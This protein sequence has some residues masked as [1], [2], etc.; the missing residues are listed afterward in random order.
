MRLQVDKLV[1][2]LNFLQARAEAKHK[3]TGSGIPVQVEPVL[4]IRIDFNPDPNTDPA[5]WL[6]PDTD[7][8][9]QSHL[10]RIQYGS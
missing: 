6:N 1:R 2:K 10:I 5:F 7:S 9:P 8:D 3:V 4:S